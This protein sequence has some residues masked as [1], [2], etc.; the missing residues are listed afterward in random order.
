MPGSGASRAHAVW[1]GCGLAGLTAILIAAPFDLDVA[2]AVARFD[3]PFAVL[4]QDHGTHPALVVYLAA[5]LWLAVPSLRRRARLVS[6]CAS[7]VLVQ[8][9]VHTMLAVNV[10]KLLWGRERFASVAAGHASYSPIWAIDP[11]GGGVSFPSGH[12]A[13]AL[14]LL[15]AAFILAQSGRRGAAIAVALGSA[16]FASAIGYGRLRLGAHYLTDVLFSAGTAALMAPISVAI[17][18]RYLTLFERAKD[19][20]SRQ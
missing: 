12:V 18:D 7:A 6:R 2:R 13:T 5:I 20:T 9:L 11:L 14:V 10:L 17:G 19:S 1:I 4:V 15:P 3:D 8:A 16:A